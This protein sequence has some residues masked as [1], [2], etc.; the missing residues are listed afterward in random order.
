MKQ[1]I[2]ILTTL[3][4]TNI[5]VS[6]TYA[7]APSVNCFW[8]PWC[9]DSN[10]EKPTDANIENNIWTEVISNIIGQAI[11]FVAVIAVISLIASWFLYLI[12]WW[13]EEKVKKAKTWIIWSLAWVLLSISAWWIVSMLNKITIW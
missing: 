6:N 12:S 2:L 9:S 13:E 10:I 1:K 7:E 4:L 5:F 3:L 11:Q 8:L